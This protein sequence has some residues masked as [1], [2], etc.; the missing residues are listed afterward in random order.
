MNAAVRFAWLGFYAA[1]LIWAGCA[2]PDLSK[3]VKAPFIGA[4]DSTTVVLSKFYNSQNYRKWLGR[5][6]QSEGLG[7]LRFVQAYGADSAVF[8]QEVLRAGAVVLT[9]GEDIHP[10]RYGQ[11]EDTIRCGRIDVERDR[12]EHLLLDR[13]LELGLPCLGV[14]RGLQVMNVHG[15]GSLH[16]HLPD[17]GY[18]GHRG[19]S[20]GQ[21]RDTL[22]EVRITHPWLS[23]RVEFTEGEAGPFVSHHHQGIDRLSDQ[24]WAWAEGPE[25]LTEGIRHRDTLKVPFLVGVQWHPERSR[26]GE[27][28]SDG[29]G[30]ALLKA[31]T[32]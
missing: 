16:A 6:A 1:A 19:G 13:V 14:C 32:P 18:A 7:P 8:E 24:Y 23:G 21:T 31:G 9:G 4:S 30:V 26:S 5:L 15:G 20:P 2:S 25:G 28:L 29:L 27:P 22:H 10:A 3:P 11:A 17:A 12:V